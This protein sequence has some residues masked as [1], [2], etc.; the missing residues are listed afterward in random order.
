MNICNAK[1]NLK[2]IQLIFRYINEDYTGKSHMKQSSIKIVGRDIIWNIYSFLWRSCFPCVLQNIC[3]EQK[4]FLPSFTNKEKIGY[5]IFFLELHV[6]L[7]LW[8]KSEYF[9]LQK[10]SK[11]SRAHRKRH[12]YCEHHNFS[13]LCSLSWLRHFLNSRTYNDQTM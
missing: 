1:L 9:P 5:L 7:A 6:C 13:T 4:Y 12:K 8:K 2:N 11:S 10:S 3:Q